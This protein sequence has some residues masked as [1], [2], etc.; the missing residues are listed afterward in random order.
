VASSE[1]D[2]HR[3]AVRPG[4]ALTLDP[5]LAGHL[6][7]ALTGYSR[8]LR[9]SGRTVPK[10]VDDLLAG[11]LGVV[12]SGQRLAPDHRGRHDGD[13]FLT[14][15][16]AAALLRLSP[17]TLRRRIAAGDLAVHRVGRRPLVERADLLA[18]VEAR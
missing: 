16:E 18:F 12:T 17:R 10:G 3:K 4:A 7:V 11:A 13:V 9:S 15:P 2:R 1:S 5:I 8:A 14:M 6:A